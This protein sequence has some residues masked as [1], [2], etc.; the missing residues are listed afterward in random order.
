MAM[1]SRRQFAK[2]MG[3][4]LAGAACG[5]F[6]AGCSSHDVSETALASLEDKR[7]RPE[8]DKSSMADE[9]VVSVKLLA[10]EAFRLVL[11]ALV[12]AY[13]AEHANVSVAVPDFA[14]TGRIVSLAEEGDYDAVL[15]D[16][17]SAV[18]ALQEK[19]LTDEMRRFSFFSGRVQVAGSP[20]MEQGVSSL[21][22]IA[23]DGVDAVV[24]GD[25]STVFSGAYANQALY[26]LGWY[27][28]ES[29]VG[30]QYADDLAPKVRIAA[31]AEEL[32]AMV[33]QGERTVGL[34]TSADALVY[35]LDVLC[36]VPRNEYRQIYYQGAVLS[37][38]SAPMLAQDFLTFCS[39]ETEAEK[40]GD[41]FGMSYE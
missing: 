16:L 2:A 25:A 10:S 41:M 31:T 28:K 29:G 14:E 1:L 27:S 38:G 20:D 21:E 11:P 13:R 22:D 39:T 18:L 37:T 4:C 19:G 23:G 34:T 35:G 30:G 33:A 8:A 24:V 3:G 36:E 12:D 32:A 6:L 7:R 40:V 5:G 9:P 15:L 26:R 17:T